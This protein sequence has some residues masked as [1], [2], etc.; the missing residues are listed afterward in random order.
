[1][2]NLT[3]DR[4]SRVLPDVL[5]AQR[6]PEEAFIAMMP[7]ID[8]AAADLMQ[9]DEALARAFLTDWSAGAAERLFEDWRELA[10]SI[11]TKHVDGYVRDENGRSRGVG[12]SEEA[13][14]AMSRQVE[15][16]LRDF[17]I[18]VE[19]VAV[20][21]GPVVTLFELQLAAGTK[22]SRIMMLMR[23]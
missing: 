17:G 18:E 9:R 13:L 20:H 16:K 19:V 14:Q 12:Y 2:S 8:Q 7:A 21:P 15:L 6:T 5:A 4:W 3:Y 1:M 10:T 22:V 23:A 11:L